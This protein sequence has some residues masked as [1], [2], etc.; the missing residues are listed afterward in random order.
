MHDSLFTS[1]SVQSIRAAV[2]TA[3]INRESSMPHQGRYFLA[4]LPYKDTLARQ[5]NANVI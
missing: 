4:L 3:K 1:I 2:L 5:T